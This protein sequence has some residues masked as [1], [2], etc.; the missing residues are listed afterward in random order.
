MAESAGPWLEG[1]ACPGQD[2]HDPGRGWGLASSVPAELRK[3]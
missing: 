2:D 3:C 1:D